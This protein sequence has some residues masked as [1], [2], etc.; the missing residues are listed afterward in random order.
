MSKA[1]A[2]PSSEGLAPPGTLPGRPVDADRLTRKPLPLWDRIKFLVMLALIWL[3]LTW[4]VMANDPLVG[5]SDAVRIEVRTG[6]WVFVLGRPGGY[7]PDPL[8]DQRA[9][10]GI[11]PVLD[12]GGLRGHGADHS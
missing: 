2:A 9:L 7:P 11:P 12:R 6:W 4:S 1:Q 3:I 10:A 5:F 8:P